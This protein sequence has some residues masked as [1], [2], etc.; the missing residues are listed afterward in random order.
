MIPKHDD[1][2]GE[3]VTFERKKKKRICLLGIGVPV[4]EWEVWIQSFIVIDK[5]TLKQ[6][7]LKDTAKNGKKKIV[8]SI[9][10]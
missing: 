8:K 6:F 9:V 7:W 2:I 10:W 4:T 3:L 5:K 1:F